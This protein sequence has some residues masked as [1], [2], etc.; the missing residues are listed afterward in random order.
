MPTV[1]TPPA[2]TAPAAPSFYRWAIFVLGIVIVLL[3]LYRATDS[4]PETPPSP[5]RRISVIPPFAL[6]ERSGRP[7]TNRD[8]AGKIWVADFVYTT[9]PGPCPLVTAELARVQA[10]TLSDPHVQLVTFTVDPVTDTPGVLA[11]YADAFHADPNKWW[12]LTGPEKPMDDLIQNG[13]LQAVQNNRGQPLEQGQGPVT[14]S[15]YFALIDAQGNMRQVYDS[16]GGAERPELLR[17]IKILEQEEG[18]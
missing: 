9:C 13:F 10:A 12:F 16:T 6:T 18:L 8:L 7:I 11:R 4:G 2:K 5:L 17:D 1:Q 14:H 3:V 15:L